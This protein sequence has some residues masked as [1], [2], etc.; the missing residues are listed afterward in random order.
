MV[1]APLNAAHLGFDTPCAKT[2]RWGDCASALRIHN[3]W[4]IIERPFI[5]N[6]IHVA[7]IDEAL[8]L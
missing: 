3:A 7:L 2:G 4:S 8:G 1:I 6:R 5:P